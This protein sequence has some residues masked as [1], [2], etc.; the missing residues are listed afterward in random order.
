MEEKSNELLERVKQIALQI[1]NP[2]GPN[3]GLIQ[4]DDKAFRDVLVDALVRELPDFQH[5]VLE[6]GPTQVKDLEEVLREKMPPEILESP[7]VKWIIHVIN[8]EVSLYHE[9]WTGE[10]AFVEKMNEATAAL[11]SEFPFVSLIYADEYLSK[12]LQ[13]QASDFWEAVPLRENFI[14]HRDEEKAVSDQV[15]ELKKAFQQQQDAGEKQALTQ[16]IGD[17][18]KIIFQ[19]ERPDWAMELLDEALLYKEEAEDSKATAH[20][21]L[22]KGMCYIRKQ[23][24]ESGLELIDDALDIYESAEAYEELAKGYFLLGQLY[25]QSGN[26]DE[27]VSYFE[28]SAEAA[29]S[30]ENLFYLAQSHQFLARAQ[31]R[32][33]DLEAAAAHH[34]AAGAALLQDR[35]PL[36]AAKAWQQQGAVLQDQRKWVESLAAFQQAK[37]TAAELDDDFLN[38]ALE[39]SIQDMQEKADAKIKKDGKRKGLFG[40]LRG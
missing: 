39:D 5:I 30:A 20:A 13:E 32:L 12:R 31:E 8:L 17:F 29:E 40:R 15:I 22:V 18:G 3:F 25:I 14:E 38:A 33:G 6:L 4:F 26:M 19:S 28:A 7:E 21:L 10:S 11:T 27:A 23:E 16:I 2:A 35:K 37:K 9:L 36:E 34:A 24:T 1:A